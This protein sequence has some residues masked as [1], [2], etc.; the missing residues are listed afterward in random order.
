MAFDKLPPASCNRD[1]VHT[2]PNHR[3]CGSASCEVGGS[4]SEDR[5]KDGTEAVCICGYTVGLVHREMLYTQLPSLTC[6]CYQRSSASRRTFRIRFGLSARACVIRAKST[7]YPV[8]SWNLSAFCRSK[9]TTHMS[10]S[11]VI[12]QVLWADVYI[13]ICIFQGSVVGRSITVPAF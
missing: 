5:S 11:K 9:T 4:S 2:A 6:W 13:L 12:V 10:D 7:T 1:H 3:K 8:D